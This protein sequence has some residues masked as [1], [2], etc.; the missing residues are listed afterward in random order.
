ML[1]ALVIITNVESLSCKQRCYSTGKNAQYDML[2]RS[3]VFALA[4]FKLPESVA[5]SSFT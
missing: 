2:E 1:T 3:E 5:Y 4:S